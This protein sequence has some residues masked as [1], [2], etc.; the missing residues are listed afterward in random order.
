METIQALHRFAS[1]ENFSNRAAICDGVK[2]S[3]FEK[4]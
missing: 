4:P 1:L 3:D 2:D